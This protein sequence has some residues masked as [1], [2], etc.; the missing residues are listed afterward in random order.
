MDLTKINKND[1]INAEIAKHSARKEKTYHKETDG[2]RH[3]NLISQ[4]ARSILCIGARDDSEV[5]S[6]IN[7]GFEAVGIDLFEETE[8]IKQIDAHEMDFDEFDF[9]YASHILEHLYDPQVVMKKI[10]KISKYGVFV[11]LPIHKQR[12]PSHP[13]HFDIMKNP[14]DEYFPDSDFDDFL[15]YTV[16]HYKKFEAELEI[17]FTW[18]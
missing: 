5:L 1:F 13:A 11:I 14:P 6:F 16:N 4:K 7:A 10:R 17:M 9:I 8:Y 12:K 3:I 18:N 2:K 15:P